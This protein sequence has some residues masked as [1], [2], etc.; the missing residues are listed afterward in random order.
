MKKLLCSLTALLFLCATNANAGMS[1]SYG[2][3]I[4]RDNYGQIV[5]RSSTD[6]RGNTRYKDRYGR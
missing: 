6:S 1:D 2:N 4:C 3:R 5:S